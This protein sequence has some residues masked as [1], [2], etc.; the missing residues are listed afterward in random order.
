MRIIVDIPDELFRQ[1]VSPAA[2]PTRV[3]LEDFAAESYRRGNLTM[4]QVRRLLG[5]GTPLQ[6]DAFLQRHQVYDYTVQELE[7]DLATL[8]RLAGTL[9]GEN[10]ES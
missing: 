9:T 4:E 1:V 10:C 6:V 8:D 2:D 5:F 3:L 7:K